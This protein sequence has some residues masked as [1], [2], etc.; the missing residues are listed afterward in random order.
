[1]QF[2]FVSSHWNFF[3]FA[4]PR[5]GWT[6]D[7][8][9]PYNYQLF[10]YTHTVERNHKW[11]LSDTGVLF[12]IRLRRSSWIPKWPNVFG[13]QLWLAWRD[14][15]LGYSTFPDSPGRVTHT[16]H[17]MILLAY[18]HRR[19]QCVTWSLSSKCILIL[20]TPKAPPWM[21]NNRNSSGVQNRYYLCF[22]TVVGL[23]KISCY[24]G[25][26]RKPYHDVIKWN[27]FP[28]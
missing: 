14:T 3:Q 15:F 18:M 8:R 21:L 9:S 19:K 1:M 24:H 5:F 16:Q 6:L 13:V 12:N 22:A 28:C 4:L 20:D 7:V 17:T 27:P 11:P 10:Q 2:P 26:V 23:Y 25:P